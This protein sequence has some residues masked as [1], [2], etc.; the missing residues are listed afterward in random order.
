MNGENIAPVENIEG[1]FGRLEV[2][3]Y[4][5]SIGKP[6]EEA[7]VQVIDPNSNEVLEE[8]KTDE[9]GNIPPITL[10]TPP[11]EYSLQDDLPRP[12]NQY[13]VLVTYPN[14]QEARIQNVQLYP[15]CTAVQNVVMRPSFNEIVIPYPVLWGGLPA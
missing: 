13:N 5:N 12:F 7:L 15:D 14:Y 3:T 11:I 8:L 1:G 2:S 4:L 6:A 9:E 10:A